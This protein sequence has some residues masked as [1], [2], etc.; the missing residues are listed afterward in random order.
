MDRRRLLGKVGVVTGGGSG[1]G[2]ATAELFAQEGAKVAV[3]DSVSL[4]GEETVQLIEK[5]GGDA[6]YLNADVSMDDQVRQMVES[7]ISKFKK[8]DILFNNVGQNLYKPVLDVEERE[9]DHILAVNLKSVYLGS[10]Y[11]LPYMIKGG[12]GSIV[13]T[14]STFGLIGNPKMPAY[15][16]SKGA[17]VSLTRQMALD[18]ASHNVRVNCV[19]PGPTLTPRIAKKINSVEDPDRYRRDLIST[20]PLGRFAEAIEIAYSVLF[21]AS[22]ESSFV[23]GSALVVDGGQT[24]H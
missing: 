1:I 24:A 22:D 14:A 23:T 3:V 12:G 15:C 8:I 17:I 13:N 18:Y 4:S 16:A 20:V 2:R 9:W 6:L 11:A 21:L 10:K 7:T 5:G 19:C